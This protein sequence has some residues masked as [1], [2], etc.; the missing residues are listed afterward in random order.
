MLLPSAPFLT[1]NRVA[2]AKWI[3][4]GLG[5][6]VRSLLYTIR[7]ELFTIILSRIHSMSR[8]YPRVVVY[9]WASSRY[10]N[11]IWVRCI[12]QSQCL[13]QL[14]P[15]LR[16][17]YV[18]ISTFPSSC[19][20]RS[21]I[22]VSRLQSR[23]TFVAPSSVYSHEIGTQAGECLRSADWVPASVSVSGA[24]G[25]HIPRYIRSTVIDFSPWNLNMYF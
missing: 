11:W 16:V 6:R 25:L 1:C 7:R 2:W 5:T 17:D 4:N 10:R 13:F 18:L 21:S 15:R 12:A 24:F 19:S 8:Y 22:S 23:S 9:S 3:G 14:Y 20:I